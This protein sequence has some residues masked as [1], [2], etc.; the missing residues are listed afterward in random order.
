MAA[1]AKGRYA[2]RHLSIICYVPDCQSLARIQGAC[3]RHYDAI[4]QLHRLRTDS[5]FREY[6]AGYRS[7]H[8]KAHPQMMAA[9]V[10]RAKRVTQWATYL[11]QA[12]QRSAKHRQI[13]CDLDADYLRSLWE[14]QRGL[15]Y[16]LG[17][18]MEPS[19]ETRSPARPSVDRLVPARGYTRG[20]VVLSTQFA[21]MGRNACSAERF[22]AFVALLREKLPR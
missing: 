10:T 20:N 16:W 5:D 2:K 11:A 7:R 18:P 4:R 17:I 8:A 13:T 9:A 1:W 19:I 21:N 3:K 22:A 15:C 12:C 14:Q 6:R